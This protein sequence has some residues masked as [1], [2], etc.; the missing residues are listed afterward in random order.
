MK[1][2]LKSTSGVLGNAG[3]WLTALITTCAA[4]GTLL[5]SAQ[6]LGLTAWLGSVDLGIT[7]HAA[8][9]V[10]I[11][12]RADTLF[13]VEDTSVLAATVTD[14]RGGVL[15]GVLINW[16]SEDTTVAVVDTAGLV[17]A[18]GPGTTKITAGVRDLLAS[19]RITVRQRPQRMALAGD[20]A[21]RL[22]EGDTLRLLAAAVDAHGHRVR[23]LTPRWQS[24]DTTVAVVDSLGLARAR[25]PGRTV[26]RARVGELESTV[27]VEVDLAPSTLGI[28]SGN[29]Q[30]GPAGRPL[31]EPI[32]VLVLSR[33][34]LPVPGVGV[35]LAAD[36]GQ[37]DPAGGTTDRSGLLRVNWTLGPRPGPQRLHARVLTL[38]S[39]ASVLA[40]ADPLPGN[41]RIELLST[42]PTGQVGMA[43]DEP[44]LVK[45]T[46]TAG[47]PMAD[48]PVKWNA[49]DRGRVSAA[50]ERTDSLGQISAQWTLGP[51]AGNQRLRAEVGNP[52]TLAPF[53]VTA[54]AT[55]GP[56]SRLV[57]RSGE[58]QKGVVGK[59]LPQPLTVVVLDSAGNVVLD[60]R[61]R[62]HA[63]SGGLA[64][65]A[66]K[67]D[68]QGRTLVRW[69]LGE[70][71]GDQ[72]LRL[73]T[74]GVDSIVTAHALAEAGKAAAL[75]LKETR[76]K[77][78]SGS[79]LAIV[80]SVTDAHGNP[81][82]RAP[83]T[84][85]AS[86]GKLTTTHRVTDDSG[87]VATS[88]AP[89]VKAAEQTLTAKVTGTSLSAASVFKSAPV[90]RATPAKPAKRNPPVTPASRTTAS[91]TPAHRPQ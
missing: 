35:M 9:R 30:R 19:A 54:I 38:D 31:A 84:F 25:G 55:S 57:V 47:A 42:L 81:V 51:H 49:L 33:G 70:K 52:H 63:L 36:G 23:G 72:Q 22:L 71:A 13:A 39:T 20:T 1:R 2:T 86:G 88:W 5:V 91:R 69:K 17:V 40:E 90:T 50:A 7:A 74:A 62:I 12:P 21:V 24:G 37:V 77:T 27:A 66:P 10:A 67:P 83:V 8:R 15:V 89:A 34:G 56:P 43:L 65:T 58:G 16:S 85:S 18:R 48:V 76:A 61:V 26:L 4:L 46:D 73:R 75:T 32:V 53:V 11:T 64:D 79:P 87:H 41:T 6:N 28:L 78:A 82:A 14:R 68:L 80:A 45:V 29:G 60:A 3:K 59:S 44:I